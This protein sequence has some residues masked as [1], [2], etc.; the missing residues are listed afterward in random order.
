MFK[1]EIYHLK[2]WN[3]SP[4]LL[5]YYCTSMFQLEFATVAVIRLHCQKKLNSANV[6]FHFNYMMIKTPSSIFLNIIVT[7]NFFLSKEC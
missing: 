2:Y 1:H 6:S 3:H 4:H 5:I 7:F